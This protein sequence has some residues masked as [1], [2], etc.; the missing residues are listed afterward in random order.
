MNKQKVSLQHFS[1]HSYLAQID[2]VGWGEPLIH[3]Q[4]GDILAK[5]RDRADRR[6]RIALTTNGV[7]LKKWANRLIEANVREIAVSIHAATPETHDDLMGLPR[8][9]VCRRVGRHS[10]GDGTQ[11][12]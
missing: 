9:F 3:P 11:I 5:L 10:L 1:C 12:G 8:G 4:F 7:H 6:A 2:M